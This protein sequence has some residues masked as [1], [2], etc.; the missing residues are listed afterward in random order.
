MQNQFNSGQQ[1]QFNSGQQPPGQRVPSSQSAVLARATLLA[2]AIFI[3]FSLAATKGQSL[4]VAAQYCP[5]GQQY[6]FISGQQPPGQRVPSSQS[7]VSATFLATAILIIF[8][9][10]L[11]KGQSPDVAAQYCPS[12]QQYQFISGQ[13]PPG[14]RVPSS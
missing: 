12:G 4:E 2:V 8:S 9:L 6:Q 11:T 3:S 10:M 7:L 5:S 14:Q 1:N 13:Q